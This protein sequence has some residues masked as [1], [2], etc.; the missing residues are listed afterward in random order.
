MS[1]PLS[2]LLVDDAPADLLLAQEVFDDHAPRVQLTTQ[3]GAEA[4]LLALRDPAQLPPDMVLVDL[5][6]NGMSGLDFLAE[7]RADPALA[8]LPVVMLS[9]STAQHDVDR[10]Y[11]LHATAFLV[12]APN[13]SEFVAQVD[14][15]VQFWLGC[16]F[17]SPRVPSLS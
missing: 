6:M 14:H 4:A 1:R 10:A 13:L 2:V 8:H 5:N 17:R 11:D 16:R 15:L 7:L 9:G 12:K 3:C